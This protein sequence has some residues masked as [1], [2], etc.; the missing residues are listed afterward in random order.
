MDVFLAYDWSD[1]DRVLEGERGERGA[2]VL[3]LEHADRIAQA[4]Q[5]IL[6][7]LDRSDESRR[8]Y[9]A[10]TDDDRE[11]VPNPRQRNHPMPLPVDQGLYDTWEAVLGDLRRL[12]RGEEGLSAADLLTLS[13]EEHEGRPHGYVDLGHMLSYPHDVTLHVRDLE[14]LER[15]RDLDGI[16]A[17]LL[18]DNY[19]PSMK[20]SPLPGRLLR[21]KGQ[22]D[23]REE[24]LE[25]KLRYLF[26]LN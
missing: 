14:R 2:F 26:W 18:G 16:L 21:M 9:L 25:R 6:E 8:A 17:S 11:W 24:G 20:P 23:R 10:E 7:G 1:V 15:G 4:R 3:R 13:G 5:R 22:I 19:V 12:V